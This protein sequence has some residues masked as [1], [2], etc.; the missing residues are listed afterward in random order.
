MT[1]I[2]IYVV[3]CVW[4][5]DKMFLRGRH[6]SVSEIIWKYLCVY[7]AGRHHRGTPRH[8]IASGNASSRCLMQRLQPEKRVA[9]N[10]FHTRQALRDGALLP[11]LGQFL[12]KC[13]HRLHYVRRDS[14]LSP[15]SLFR[16]F[17]ETKQ[18]DS[19][20]CC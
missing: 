3:S 12:R 7:T 17:L 15:L 5:R 13:C 1:S 20:R 9:L 11:P 18:E 16:C 6:N 19:G 8:D 10:S 2:C 4:G 14:R